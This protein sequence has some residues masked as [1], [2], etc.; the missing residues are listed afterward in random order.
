MEFGSDRSH[1]VKGRL[2]T[3]RIDV[4][5]SYRGVPS[6][7]QLRDTG[8]R[9]NWAFGRGVSVGAGLFRSD[10]GGDSSEWR[11]LSFRVPVGRRFGL[12]LERSLTVSNTLADSSAAAMIDLRAGSL[13]VLHRYQWGT[14]Q[15]PTAGG[16][17]TVNHEQLQSMAAYSSGPR[18]NVTLQSAAQWTFDG[19]RQQWLELQANVR[20]S[21]RT[22]LQVAAPMPGQFDSCTTACAART[23]ITRTLRRRR[24]VWAPVV[25]PA[26][27]ERHRDSSRQGSAPPYLGCLYGC[28]RGKRQWCRHR[29]HWSTGTRRARPAGAIFGGRGYE[30]RLCLRER[31][32][33]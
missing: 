8:I 7:I 30:W 21:A 1:F 19:R 29:L 16:A 22:S 12:T 28:P 25:V 18:L 10:R 11:T 20:A 32:A 4:E 13:L 6:T 27:P 24:G 9:A 17:A 26:G 5:A 14:A 15:F 3:R 23:A 2:A 33:R 31:A